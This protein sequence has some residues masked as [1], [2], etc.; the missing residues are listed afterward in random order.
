MSSTHPSKRLAHASGGGGS[1]TCG[2]ACA[3]TAEAGELVCLPGGGAARALQE[4]TRAAKAAASFPLSERTGT[5]PFYSDWDDY[6]LDCTVK[7]RPVD[8][9]TMPW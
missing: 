7:V 2:S 1:G 8:P 6:G 9:S 3:F 4:R 5:T